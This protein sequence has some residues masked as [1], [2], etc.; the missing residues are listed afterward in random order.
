MN[1]DGEAARPEPVLLT[2]GAPFSF[3]FYLRPRRQHGH[4][5]DQSVGRPR[6]H[7]DRERGADEHGQRQTQNVGGKGAEEQNGHTRA[8]DV[9]REI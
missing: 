2:W 5:R 3:S 1:R 6:P 9:E 7:G 8:R 4:E